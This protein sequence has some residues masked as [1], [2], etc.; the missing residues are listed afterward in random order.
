M[1]FLLLITEGKTVID[2]GRREVDDDIID[3]VLELAISC[4]EDLEEFFEDSL[5][6]WISPRINNNS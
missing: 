2:I 3:E 1:R 4:Y 6:I 5:H